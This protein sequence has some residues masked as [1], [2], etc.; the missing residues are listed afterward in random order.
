MIDKKVKKHLKQAKKYYI[1]EID[2]LNDI[3]KKQSNLDSV[4]VELK[5]YSDLLLELNEMLE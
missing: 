4:K 5:E 2:V 1:R 3:L